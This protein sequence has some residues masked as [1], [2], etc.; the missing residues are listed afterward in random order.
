MR[1]RAVLG[2]LSYERNI[3]RRAGGD[4]KPQQVMR[5]RNVALGQIKRDISRRGMDTRK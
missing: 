5:R 3:A 4:H 1:P 2:R